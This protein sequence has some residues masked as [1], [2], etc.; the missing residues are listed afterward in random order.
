MTARARFTQ[1]DLTRVMKAAKS[2]GY[3]RFSVT[4]DTDG[5]I[6]LRIHSAPTF[7]SETNEWA[8]LE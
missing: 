7:V 8:D 1:A 6:E 2:A 3:E 4:I 5:T